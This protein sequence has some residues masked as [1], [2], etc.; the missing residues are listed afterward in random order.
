MSDEKPTRCPKDKAGVHDFEEE[1]MYGFDGQGKPHHGVK[2][3]CLKCG[4]QEFKAIY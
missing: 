2:L 4:Y 1:R 3:T